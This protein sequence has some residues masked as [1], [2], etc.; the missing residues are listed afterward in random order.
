VQETSIRARDQVKAKVLEMMEQ[1]QKIELREKELDYKLT[2]VF[3][4][5]EINSG[6]ISVLTSQGG[7]NA[8]RGD[9]NYNSETQFGFLRDQIADERKLRENLQIETHKLNQQ[10]NDQIR[11]VESELMSKLKDTREQQMNLWKQIDEDKS[12]NAK[13]GL[14]KTDDSTSM[15][16]TLLT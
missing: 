1:M 5:I 15:I 2:S 4:Q 13:Y 10:L 8:E 3:K 7:N 11:Q 6:M 9:S 16:R 14:D 12:A